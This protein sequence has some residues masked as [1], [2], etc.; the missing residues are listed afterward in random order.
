MK[1]LAALLLLLTSSAVLA[2][3]DAIIEWDPALGADG[4]KVYRK[5]EKCDAPTPSAQWVFLVDV[6]NATTYTDPALPFGT[7]VCYYATA[8]ND[9]GESLPSNTDGKVVKPDRPGNLR[10]K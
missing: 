6:G 10:N 5:F 7:K 2:N 4:Y 1:R 9:G 3:E 8:Y